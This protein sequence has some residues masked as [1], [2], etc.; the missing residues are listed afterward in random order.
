M[1]QVTDH[2]CQWCNQTL[3]K[4]QPTFSGSRWVSHGMGCS[5]LLLSMTSSIRTDSTRSVSSPRR[6]AHLLVLCRIAHDHS[7]VDRHADVVQHIVMCSRQTE[8]DACH[9]ISRHAFRR[10]ST[11]QLQLHKGAS[12]KPRSLRNPT[13]HSRTNPQTCWHAPSCSERFCQPV[14][15]SPSWTQHPTQLDSTQRDAQTCRC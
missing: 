13:P 3:L 1:L 7:H 10:G 8:G 12:I 2:E 6:L 5:P 4:L 9:V 11:R 15:T 14:G